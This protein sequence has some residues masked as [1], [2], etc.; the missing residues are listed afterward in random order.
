MER[1]ADLDDIKKIM[2]E[3]DSNKEVPSVEVSKVDNE[4]DRGKFY[5]LVGELLT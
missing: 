4:V 1:G 2:Q 5:F 3:R